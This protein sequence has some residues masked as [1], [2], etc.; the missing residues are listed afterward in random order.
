MAYIKNR[1]FGYATPE[2][3]EWVMMCDH[4]QMSG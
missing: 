2:N 1:H 4:Q 3:M